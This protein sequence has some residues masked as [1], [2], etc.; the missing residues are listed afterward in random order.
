MCLAFATGAL[1]Q[2]G[3]P[4]P[5]PAR[6]DFSPQHDLEPAQDDLSV[7]LLKGIF[8]TVI[9]KVRLA[10][11][12]TVTDEGTFGELFR[13]FNSF[14]L[15][16]LAITL[17]VKLVASGL[18][19]A[20]DGEA[21]GRDRSAVWAPVRIVI[22]ASLLIPMVNGY[23][24]IQVIV[25]WTALMGAGLADTIWNKAVDQFTTRALYTR[26]PP[27]EARELAVA[28]LASGV[29]EKVMAAIPARG[30]SSF[31]V[32]KFTYD[33][34]FQEFLLREVSWG[35]GP[36]GARGCGGLT[37]R[38]PHKGIR[39]EQDSG[40][41]DGFGA[42]IQ[43]ILGWTED[44]RIE[45]VDALLGAHERAALTMRAELLPL[46]EQIVQGKGRLDDCVVTPVEGLA[47]SR[48]VSVIDAAAEHY[49]LNLRGEIAAVIDAAAQRAV[50]DFKGK[51]KEEGWLTAGTWFYRLAALTDYMNQL[52]LNVP[53]FYDIGAWNKLPR[54]DVETYQYAISRLGAVIQEADTPT[55]FD[56]THGDPNNDQL[57][58]VSRNFLR[59]VMSFMQDNRYSQAHPIF[60]IA[61]LGHALL[62]A[63]LTTAFAGWGL[64]KLI[65]AGK[66]TDAAGGFIGVLGGGVNGD[67]ALSV[68]SLIVAVILLA[69]IAFALMAAIHIPLVPF[70]IWMVGILSWILLVFEALL[71]GPIWAIWH[72]REGKGFLTETTMNGYLLLFSLLLRPTLMLFGLLGATVISYYLLHLVSTLFTIAAANSASGNFT[73]G[74]VVAG[75]VVVFVVVAV[76]LTLKCFSLVHRLPDFTLRWIGGAMESAVDAADLR[77]RA[78][79]AAQ[80][81]AQ[82][83]T[84]TVG[85]NLKRGPTVKE[86]GEKG[87][88]GASSDQQRGKLH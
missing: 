86:M 88:G 42:W 39:A 30:G 40:V 58:D 34:Y 11:V 5:A 80:A 2:P 27:P 28:M 45:Y 29:C 47:A 3:N 55:E 66:L 52:A 17:F 56:I 60:A 41:V 59:A 50:V 82:M 44:V 7:S 77:Q 51:A 83:V 67:S 15:F 74:V 33:G 36:L 26:P 38:D 49:T 32:R 8:G 72:I 37:V 13:I 54:E 85:D 10:D 19:T 4:P 57:D 21:L 20:A 81:G 48:C 1:A 63:I 43:R 16:L 61:W 6:N 64:S 78:E 70:I 46:A 23:A 18:D 12:L 22:A 87:G 75:F 31:A 79:G 9:D 76:E 25:L 69:L 71:A 24:L 65:P 68:F 53:R 35:S 62:A 14:V 73:G 84:K